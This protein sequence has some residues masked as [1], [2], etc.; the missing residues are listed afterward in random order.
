MWIANRC[1]ISMHAGGPEFNRVQR[2]QHNNVKL[3]QISPCENFLVTWS[4]DEIESD[5]GSEPH[6]LCI[7]DIRSGRK[8]RGFPCS[9]KQLVR[10]QFAAHVA[11][12]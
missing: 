3:V 2:F 11:L 7:W 10:A 1:V 9:P 4:P 8:L 5:D 6:H 12:V